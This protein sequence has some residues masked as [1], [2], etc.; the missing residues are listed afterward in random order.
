MNQENFYAIL[1]HLNTMYGMDMSNS[2]F[3]NIA[4]HAWD[5]IGN[6]NYTLYR[7]SGHTTNKRLQLPCNA[8]IIESVTAPGQSVIHATGT[9]NNSEY[10]VN[11]SI[12][13]NIEQQSSKTE[14]LYTSGHF[15]D[16]TLHEN[17]LLFTREYEHVDVLYKGVIVDDEGLP[18][19]NFKEKDA[20]AKYCAFVQLQKQAMVS[21]D[22]STWEMSQIFKQQWQ[23]AVDDARTPIYLNQNDMDNILNVQSSWD[24]KRFGLT[25]KSIR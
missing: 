4:L 9:F 18:L 12:E 23:Y 5:Q 6:K 11:Q 17:N 16:Y 1:A 24:R 2:S 14:A 22:K 19:V 8:D 15:I 7:M 25:F 13:D 3:E 20:I 10:F 21:K